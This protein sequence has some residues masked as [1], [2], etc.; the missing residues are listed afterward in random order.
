VCSAGISPAVRW[1]SPPTAEG[2]ECGP[3]RCGRERP[4]RAHHSRR[5]RPCGGKMPPRQP[6]GRRRYLAAA[7]RFSVWWI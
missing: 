7:R 1:A 4:A 6:A 2:I 3:K 5:G